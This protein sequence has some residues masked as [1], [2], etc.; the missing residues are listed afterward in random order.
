MAALTKNDPRVRISRDNM[1]AYLYLPGQQ[2][3]SYSQSD[4]IEILQS[5]GISHGIKEDKVQE[6]MD[7]QIYNREVLIAEGEAPQDGV[8]GYY[9]YKFDMNFS[10]KP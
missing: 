5:N 9:E 1:Q 6:M 2:A 8:D 7:Q 4:I 10:K 3:E